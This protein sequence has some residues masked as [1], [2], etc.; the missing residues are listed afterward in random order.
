MGCLRECC[1]ECLWI[2]A[3]CAGVPV[4][5]VPDR[6]VVFLFE[7]PVVNGWIG[8]RGQTK[9]EEWARDFQQAVWF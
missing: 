4:Y 2:P 7:R 5:M 1:W 9:F 6:C 3:D 8:T